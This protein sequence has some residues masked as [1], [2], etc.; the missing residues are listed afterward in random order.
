[1]L[2]NDISDSS[3]TT[4]MNE[5]MYVY[6]CNTRG[7]F[8]DK[9]RNNYRT[10]EDMPLISKLYPHFTSL[11]YSTCNLLCCFGGTKGLSTS[12]QRKCSE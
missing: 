3:C 4:C 7:V 2:D 12:Q 1:M 5:Y 8:V 11:E 10:T 9:M 6:I